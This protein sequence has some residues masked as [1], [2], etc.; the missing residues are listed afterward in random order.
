MSNLIKLH[1]P[2]EML[3]DLTRVEKSLAEKG[4]KFIA[5]VDEAGR[6]PLAGPVVAAAVILPENCDVTGIDD[7]KKL[8]PK[9]RDL[10]FDEIIQCG[11]VVAVGIIDNEAIDSCNIL[12]AA[13]MAMRKA[14]CSLSTK[15]DYVLVDGSFAIPNL[16]YP[17]LALVGGDKYCQSISAASIIAKVTRD[18]IMDRYAEMY[19]DFSFATHR[20]YPT[21]KHLEELRMYGPTKIHR[22]SFRP[23]EELLQTVE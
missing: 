23:V 19:P 21:A 17:Q 15:P 20:G 6:G 4:Y 18:R 1:R 2:F 12:K 3:P 7:S 8:S 22:K 10:L 16:N 9:R 14:V 5:G 13:L 11:A